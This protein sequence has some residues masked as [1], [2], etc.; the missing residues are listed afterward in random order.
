M[1]PEQRKEIRDGIR[2]ILSGLAKIGKVVGVEV[3]A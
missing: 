1:T 2:C 3:K